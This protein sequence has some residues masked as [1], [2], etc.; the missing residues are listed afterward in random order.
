MESGV[1]L[2][3]RQQSILANVSWPKT[4]SGYGV[5]MVLVEAERCW[6]ELHD[7]DVLV[8]GGDG[9][10]VDVFEW[11]QWMQVA[12]CDE[13]LSDLK[14]CFKK[15]FLSSKEDIFCQQQTFIVNNRQ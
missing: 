11:F 8:R 4:G 5:T 1:L 12:Q 9:R 14:K 13:R 10:K 2:V 6:I 3:E 15:L 7:R